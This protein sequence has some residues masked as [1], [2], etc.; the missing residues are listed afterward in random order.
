M[1]KHGGTWESIDNVAKAVLVCIGGMYMSP[2]HPEAPAERGNA[3]D[4]PTKPN[5]TLTLTR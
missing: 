2:C 4:N 1:E 3:A 5:P